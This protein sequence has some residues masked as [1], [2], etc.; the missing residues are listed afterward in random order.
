MMTLLANDENAIPLTVY[1]EN[2]I[3]AAAIDAT[4]TII[5][6]KGISMPAVDSR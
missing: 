6:G 2:A 1:N 5:L 3:T 4:A